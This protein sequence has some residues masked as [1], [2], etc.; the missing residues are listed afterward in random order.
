MLKLLFPFVIAYSGTAQAELGLSQ[1]FF[2]ASSAEGSW[3]V[4]NPLLPTLDIRNNYGYVQLALL[5]GLISLTNEETSRFGATMGFHWKSKALQSATAVIQP[6]LG[7]HMQRSTETGALSFAGYGQGRFGVENEAAG[8][9]IVPQLGCSW[10]PEEAMSWSIIA[11][12]GL[13]L[14]FWIE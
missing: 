2:A 12:G 1:S 13:Q 8:I 11:G 7:V 14:S 10:N 4:P 9:Y 6:G 5:D 3:A